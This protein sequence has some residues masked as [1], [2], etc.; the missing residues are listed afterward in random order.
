MTSSLTLLEFFELLD[1]SFMTAVGSLELLD[2]C[3]MTEDDSLELLD[4]CFMTEDDSSKFL[5]GLLE[6]YSG[7]WLLRD[8]LL[9]RSSFLDVVLDDS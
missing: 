6:E 7:D 5:I 9:L 3:F 2:T 4:T 8:E 1:G